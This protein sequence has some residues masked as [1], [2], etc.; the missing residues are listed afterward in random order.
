MFP[1]YRQWGG[2]A[3]GR[4]SLRDSSTRPRNLFVRPSHE[5]I[6]SGSNRANN[7]RHLH[8]YKIPLNCSEKL[9]DVDFLTFLILFNYTSETYVL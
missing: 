1:M 7:A 4:G 6:Y 8:I 9:I 2:L 5:S 3:P